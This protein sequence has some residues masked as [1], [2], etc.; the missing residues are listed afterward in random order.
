MGGGP[1]GRLEKRV[2]RVGEM[3]FDLV[4]SVFSCLG[5]RHL[6]T[7]VMNIVFLN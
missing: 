7:I 6:I 5:E 3:A 2:S 4:G 1:I